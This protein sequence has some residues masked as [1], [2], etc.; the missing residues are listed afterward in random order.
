MINAR[1]VLKDHLWIKEQCEE[2]VSAVQT[3]SKDATVVGYAMD[4]AAATRR[5]YQVLQKEC[6]DSSSVTDDRNPMVRIDPFHSFAVCVSHT[7]LVD[8]GHTKRM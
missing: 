8:Q 3:I 4:S 7:V 1:G 2:A 5:A 6:K